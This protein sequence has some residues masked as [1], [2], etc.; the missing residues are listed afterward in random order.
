MK[1]LSL[2][3]QIL[4][5]NALLVTATVFVAAIAVDLSVND[6]GRRR[7]FAVLVLAFTAVMNAYEGIP[8]PVLLLLALA[9]GTVVVGGT[10]LALSRKRD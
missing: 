1:R 2:F 3:S 4:A 10:T 6:A 8:V 9:L 7:E 5:I